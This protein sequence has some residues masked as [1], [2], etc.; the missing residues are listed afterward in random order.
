M[1]MNIFE[2]IDLWIRECLT[3]STSTIRPFDSDIAIAIIGLPSNGLGFMVRC[4]LVPYPRD[5]RG[6]MYL[7]KVFAGSGLRLTDVEDPRGLD[8]AL[9]DVSE[10]RNF[11]V[12]NNVSLSCY[13]SSVKLLS[14]ATFRGDVGT[15][16]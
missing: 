4:F 5:F 7:G 12:G 15:S 8:W 6:K 11:R 16:S 3:Y 13:S 1:G 10:S 9:I 2:N 14:H